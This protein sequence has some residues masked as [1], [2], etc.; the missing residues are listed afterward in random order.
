MC[1]KH[2]EFDYYINPTFIGFEKAPGVE[3]VPNKTIREYVNLRTHLLALQALQGCQDEKKYARVKVTPT[4]ACVLSAWRVMS[5]MRCAR[6]D[7]PTR[8]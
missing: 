1:K 2:L 3:G 6:Q 4:F 5:R 8:A 7:T